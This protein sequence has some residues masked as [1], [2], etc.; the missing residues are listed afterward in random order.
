M[1]TILYSIYKYIQISDIQNIV[2][3]FARLSVT[4]LNKPQFNDKGEAL[5]AIFDGG[6]NDT[7]SAILNDIIPNILKEERARS[8]S[9][10]I[11]LKYS[12]LSAHR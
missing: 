4:A 7:V 5:F 6:R 9:P 10:D 2:Y 11:Y 12:M 3:E 8:K 1:S